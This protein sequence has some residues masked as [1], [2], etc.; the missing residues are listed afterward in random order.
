MKTHH[1]LWL[2]CATLV[3]S[4]STQVNAQTSDVRQIDFMHPVSSDTLANYRGGASVTNSDM[5]LSG[6]TSGNTAMN[7][8]SGTNTIGMGAFANMSGLPLVVQNSGANVLIQNA[9]ILN[10]QMN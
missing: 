7:V 2:V 6:L 10:L 5:T 3:S 9:V 8:V 4:F 1:M